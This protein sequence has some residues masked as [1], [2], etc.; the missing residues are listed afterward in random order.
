M[1]AW[2]L[3]VMF[4][5]FI[6][7]GLV[8]DLLVWNM[9]PCK[10]SHTSGR[11]GKDVKE[12]KARVCDMVQWKGTHSN[13]ST[14]KHLHSTSLIEELV[15]QCTSWYVWVEILMNEPF[16]VLKGKLDPLVKSSA[17][18]CCVL[19]LGELQK[20]TYLQYPFLKGG[21]LRQLTKGTW[22]DYSNTW[23]QAYCWWTNPAPLRMPQMLG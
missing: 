19:Y 17:K 22:F 6:D 11:I 23:I 15:Y 9:A 8:G 12:Q 20:M 14:W 2:R 7:R 5:W 21:N 1:F 4:M 16:P 3:G 18:S 13:F 10:R